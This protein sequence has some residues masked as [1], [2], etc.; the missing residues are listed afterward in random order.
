MLPEILQNCQGN[1]ALAAFPRPG[2]VATPGGYS[3]LFEDLILSPAGF[4]DLGSGFDETSFDLQ[5]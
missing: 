5:V 4:S 2:Q 3:F 1:M